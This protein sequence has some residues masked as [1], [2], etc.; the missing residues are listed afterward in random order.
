MWGNPR[1]THTRCAS[2]W[3][4]GV[5]RPDTA[6][7]CRDTSP[8][9]SHDTPVDAS[10]TAPDT[11]EATGEPAGRQGGRRPSR[12]GRPEECRRAGKPAD[13]VRRG[14]VIRRAGADGRAGSG[15]SGA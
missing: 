10:T 3:K 2:D 8:H 9:E 14:S 7:T 15:R 12:L 5:F 1:P 11:T 4:P 6:V 13:G